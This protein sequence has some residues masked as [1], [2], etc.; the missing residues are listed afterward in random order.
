MAPPDALR[1]NAIS[2]KIAKLKHQIEIDRNEMVKHLDE[3]GYSSDGPGN[4]ENNKVRPYFS[5]KCKVDCE[6]IN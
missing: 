5:W 1:T 3:E 6:L 4:C 2:K